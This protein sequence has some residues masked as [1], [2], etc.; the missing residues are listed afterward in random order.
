M[1][2][3]RSG[4]SQMGSGLFFVL[5]LASLCF[6]LAPTQS[7]HAATIGMA[8]DSGALW[9][10]AS[11][12]PGAWV[13]VP[14]WVN[15]AGDSAWRVEFY[16]G[17]FPNDSTVPLPANASDVY[18]TGLS[19]P[20]SWTDLLYSSSSPRYWGIKA[21]GI[22]MPTAL[23]GSRHL[24]DIHFKMPSSAEADDSYTLQVMPGAEYFLPP[25]GNLYPYSLT[26]PSEQNNK[27]LEVTHQHLN[28]S[29]AG[30]GKV[31]VNGGAFQ[32]PPFSMMFFPSASVQLTEAPD[33]NWRFG[34]WTVN[35]TPYSSQTITI[36]MNSDKDVTATFVEPA[37]EVWGSGYYYDANN[38]RCS[39]TLDVTRSAA[40]GNPGGYVNWYDGKTRKRLASTSITSLHL[41]PGSAE[42]TGFARLNGSTGYAFSMTITDGAA[43]HCAITI[44]GGLSPIV[45]EGNL[46]KGDLAV[47]VAP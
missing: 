39:V 17:I 29:S 2:R 16:F 20:P 3:A 18:I 25:Q 24:C 46:T 44:T 6:F 31:A 22:F 10:P 21:T 7:A 19:I 34:Q 42:I 1:S 35:A 36:T 5:I 12:A 40:G 30:I 41:A 43:D 4:L 27:L 47:W 37:G 38:H 28:V 9:V 23:S 8:G 26:V 32:D 33:P 14:I 15:M 45:S 11:A 13:S